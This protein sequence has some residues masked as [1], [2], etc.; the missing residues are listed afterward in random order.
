MNYN[1]TI[2]LIDKI[3][4]QSIIF[5]KKNETCFCGKIFTFII[6]Y[7][8]A[9]LRLNFQNNCNQCQLPNLEQIFFILFLLKLI[10]N[11]AISE[12]TSL[13]QNMKIYLYSV[14]KT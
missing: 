4:I 6:D 7:N 12:K 8:C 14:H 2:F 5:E 3:Q 10:Q 9:F 13:R 11:R 1:D